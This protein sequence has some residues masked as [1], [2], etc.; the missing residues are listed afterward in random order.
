MFNDPLSSVQIKDFNASC[1]YVFQ[2]KVGDESKRLG[3][4]LVSFIEIMQISQHAAL[5]EKDT[6]ANKNRLSVLA[7]EAE[8]VERTGEPIVVSVYR[9]TP[10]GGSSGHA[11][12]AYALKRVSRNE[13]RLYVYD[14]NFPYSE[15]YIVLYTDNAGTP[16]GWYYD[17]GQAELGSYDKDC[18]I[19]FVPYSHFYTVWENRGSEMELKIGSLVVNAASYS[20]LDEAGQTIASCRNGVFTSNSEDVFLATYISGNQE[21]YSTGEIILPTG[22]YTIRNED[23][24]LERFKVQM[25]HCNLGAIVE[26]TADEVTVAVDDS[27]N[28]NLI[29]VPAQQNKEYEMTLLSS[30]D[31]DYA[32]VRLKGEIAGNAVSVSQSEGDVL[33]TNATGADLYL[34][35]EKC[36][37]TPDDV[38]SVTI[39]SLPQK[40]TYRY[41]ESTTPDLTGLSVCVHYKDGVSEIIEDTSMLQTTSINTRKNGEQTVTISYLDA[42]TDYTVQVRLT[43]W[44]R[45]FE[46][47]F[48]WMIRK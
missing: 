11:L 38:E 22:N 37:R 43:F 6:Q 36:T 30:A 19:T 2:L 3:M 12:T 35:E 44:Q 33:L 14:C 20:I 15:R 17:A 18:Y 28:T 31:S 39:Q 16:T 27:T 41:R 29:S 9:E 5:I 13:S 1:D 25:I 26:T 23:S 46:F 32:Q 42:K 8:N 7:E 10:S 4:D 40:T 48:G 34:N 47:L 21:V 45:L 24:S